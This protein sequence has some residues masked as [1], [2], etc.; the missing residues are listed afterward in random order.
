MSAQTVPA[1]AVPSLRERFLG[2][3]Q[4]AGFAERTQRSYVRHLRQV[5]DHIGRNPAALSEEEIR[6]YLLWAV[7]ERKWARKTLTIALSAIK[8]FWERTLQ[9]PWMLAKVFRPA[10][11]HTLPVVLSVEEVAQ[12]LAHVPLLRYR[13]MLTAIYSCGLRLGEAVRLEVGDVDGERKLLHIRHPKGRKD[14]F[15]PVPDRALD[16]MRDFYRTHRNPTW[17]FP[18]P[19]RGRGSE[20]LWSKVPWNLNPMHR[21]AMP[22]TLGPVQMAFRKA[23]KASGIAK[24]AHVP[25]LRHS[26]APHLLAQGVN[27]R[28]I[29]VYLGHAAPVTTAVYTHLTEQAR[30]AVR[31]PLDRIMRRLGPA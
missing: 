4:L 31:E 2:D 9:R 6:A 30:A 19:G 3:M 29:Q 28:L 15:V 16:L 27:L 26:Y 12:I 20:R 24:S 8:F 5:Q 13:A 22:V 21:A 10:L 1:A 25:T 23:L 11:N 17:I 18:R 14:R 7:N